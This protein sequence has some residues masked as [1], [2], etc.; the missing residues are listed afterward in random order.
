MDVTYKYTG[1]AAA[2]Y[3]TPFVV[4]DSW[5]E[6]LQKVWA[7]ALIANGY[8]VQQPPWVPTYESNFVSWPGTDGTM[9][10]AALNPLHFP[11]LETANLL[12][13]KYAVE[14]KQLTVI[15][16]PFLGLGP[17]MSRAIARLLQWPNGATLPAYQLA[18]YFTN[19]PEDKSDA[20]DALSRLYIAKVWPGK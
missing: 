1:T 11:T 17:V 19:N 5:A 9:Q 20:A 16:V 14:G 10:T 4:H 7:D 6:W 2:P 13:L 12:A 18:N 15:E 3:G 8:A